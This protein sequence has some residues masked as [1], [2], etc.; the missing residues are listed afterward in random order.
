M[1]HPH[2]NAP[3][4]AP[5]RHLAHLLRQVLIAGCLC[6]TVAPVC[7]LPPDIEADRL[8]QQAAHELA[9]EKD[10][11]HVVV[12]QALEAAE[13]TG[14][15]MPKNFDYHLGRSLV[16]VREFDAGKQRLER[17]LK[18]QGKNAKYYSDALEWLTASQSALNDLQRRETWT[19]FEWHDKAAGELRDRKTGL[20]WQICNSGWGNWNGRACGGTPLEHTERNAKDIA[21]SE[22][23]RTGKAWRL[24]TH[25]ELLDA[26]ERFPFVGSWTWTSTK[27]MAVAE[28]RAMRRL[29]GEPMPDTEVSEDFSGGT[30]KLH[31]RLVR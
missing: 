24:P 17:Y 10:A 29:L 23:R 5:R 12:L 11:Q 21:Q 30:S 16:A 28:S 31:V 22:A 1:S 19:R 2:R 4:R 3:A 7:A 14:A 25:S 15:R 26:A 9:K 20:I 13:A 8:L 27:G 18:A 6:Y